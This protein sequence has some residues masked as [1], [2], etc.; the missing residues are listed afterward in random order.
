[1]TSQADPAAARKRHQL[2]TWRRRQ[3]P[4]VARALA[5]R[6]DLRLIASADLDAD[7]DVPD[8]GAGVD[9]VDELP[10]DAGL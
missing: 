9:E 3:L 5:A 8:D 4:K 1:M 2:L 7:V 10:T 6:G